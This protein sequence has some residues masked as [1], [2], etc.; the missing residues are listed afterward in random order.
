MADVPDRRIFLKRSALA[1]SAVAA[2]CARTDEGAESPEASRAPPERFFPDPDLLRAVGEVVLPGELG[3]PGREEAVTGFEAWLRAYTPVP[4]RVHGY[5][6]QEIRYGPPDPAPRWAAQLEAL[7]LE[8]RA[9]HGV[10]FAGLA[11]ADRRALLERAF[12][13]APGDLPGRAGALGAEHV[14]VGFLGWFYGTPRAT[15]L[16]YG[17]RIGALSCRPLDQSGR[18]PPPLEGG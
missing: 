16:C 1:V 6:S 15:D 4:E 9:R 3:E 17:R 18:V 8:A 5:G 2:G 10:G 7:D 12:A 13:S 14:A 11:A